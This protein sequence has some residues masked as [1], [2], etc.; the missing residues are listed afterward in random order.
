LNDVTGRFAA[1]YNFTK[2]QIEVYWTPDKSV[3]YMKTYSLDTGAWSAAKTVNIPGPAGTISSY[4]TAV[5]NQLTGAI[6]SPI[7]PGR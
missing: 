2:N 7:C 1:V 4:L 3:V 5:F 6:M